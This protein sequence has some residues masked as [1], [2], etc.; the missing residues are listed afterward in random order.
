MN[1]KQTDLLTSLAIDNEGNAWIGSSKSGLYIIDKFS[2][3][4][5]HIHY[6][7]L[8]GEGYIDND[9]LDIIINPQNNS[10]WLGL[11]N[12]GICYYHP[13]LGKFSLI[14][15][16]NV[17]GKWEDQNVRSMVE[18]DNGNILLGTNSLV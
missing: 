15:N 1:I 4:V 18:Y 2:Y 7:P 9:I 11:L 10:V 3:E 13:S 17:K 14:N 5:E 6:L 12:Q 16:T 8:V